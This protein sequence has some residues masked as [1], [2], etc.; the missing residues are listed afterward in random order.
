MTPL[1]MACQPTP[2]LTPQIASLMIRAYENHWFPLMLGRLLEPIFLGRGPGWS[3]AIS[4]GDL[5]I[6]SSLDG[7]T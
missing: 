1:I 4:F 3:T 6:T 2:R 5:S 7:F